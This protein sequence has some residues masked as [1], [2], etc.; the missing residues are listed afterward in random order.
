MQRLLDEQIA[1]VDRSGGELTVGPAR[2]VVLAVAQKM[3][4]DTLRRVLGTLA[5]HMEQ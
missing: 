3:K 4:R 1:N 5:K 2:D